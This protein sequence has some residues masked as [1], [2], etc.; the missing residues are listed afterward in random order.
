MLAG[1]GL[2]ML[3]DANNRCPSFLISFKGR[4]RKKLHVIAKHSGDGR[5][6]GVHVHL[7]RSI[8]RTVAPIKAGKTVGSRTVHSFAVRLP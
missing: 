5:P 8:D 7:N 3:G 2:Y 1:H 4:V 6:M